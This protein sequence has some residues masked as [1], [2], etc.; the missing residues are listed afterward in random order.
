MIS[1]ETKEGVIEVISPYNPEFVDFAKMR[2]GKWSDENKIWMFDPRDEFAV[3]SA[4]IDIYGTDNYKSCEK[5]DIRC[6]YSVAKIHKWKSFVAG[7][8]VARSHYGQVKLSDRTIL[9]EGELKVHR[10]KVMSELRSNPILE[11]RSIPKKAAQK[12]YRKKPDKVEIIGGINETKL[13]DEKKKLQ[14][15]IDE[16][17]ELL[18]MNNKKREETEIIPDLQD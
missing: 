9:V 2:G 8:E 7:W 13:K 5:T 1:I 11:V 15:R 10:D 16:I 3:R 14:K 18:N 4:L 17:N 6:H 12:L